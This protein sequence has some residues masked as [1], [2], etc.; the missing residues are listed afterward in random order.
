MSAFFFWKNYTWLSRI[1]MFYNDLIADKTAI[2]QWSL[3]IKLVEVVIESWWIGELIV[4]TC[5]SALNIFH[6]ANLLK[7][8]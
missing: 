5:S 4:E 1:K 3:Q 2:I 6:S 8:N 7:P